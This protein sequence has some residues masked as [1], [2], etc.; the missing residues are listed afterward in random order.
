MSESTEKSTSTDEKA[1][2]KANAEVK[3]KVDEAQDK[4]YFGTVPD[5]EHDND[6][7]TLRTGPDAPPLVPDNK[8]RVAQPPL[9]TEA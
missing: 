4:G 2:A 8:T 9:K 1:A 5:D 7:Y 6:A 3:K